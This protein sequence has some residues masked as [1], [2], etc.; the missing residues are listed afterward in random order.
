[1]RVYTSETPPPDFRRRWLMLSHEVGH[2]LQHPLWGEF[3]EEFGWRALRVALA[4]GEEFVAGAQMLF[5]PLPLGFSIAYVPRGP[6]LRTRDPELLRTLVHAL[7]REA[8]RRRAVFLKVEPDWVDTEAS[9]ALLRAAGFHPSPHTVQ[10]RSTIQVDLTPSPE[11]ILARMK[12]KW[13]YNIRLAQRKG[14]LVRPA[15]ARDVPIFLELLEETAQRDGFALHDPAYYRRAWEILVP[16]GLATL[17]IAWYMDIPL[18]AIFVAAWHRTGI[19]MYGASSHRERQRMPNHLLQWEAMM[20]ARRQG[21]TVY[22]MWGIPDEVGA[23]PDVWAHRTPERTDGLWGVF[24]FKQGFGGRIVRFVGAWDR[25]YN[26]VGYRLYKW[27]VVHK[28][29]GDANV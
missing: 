11:E 7:D 24:R 26:P 23:H 19:Y 8:R 5:R 18:A 27:F 9:R 2:L 6:M 4:E 29:R 1:M 14:V 28:Q 22:D 12:A 17:L 21:C 20:W 3:K 15:E 25:V 10:P 13:R 16:A